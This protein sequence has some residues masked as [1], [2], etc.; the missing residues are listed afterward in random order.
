M[1]NDLG[2]FSSAYRAEVLKV[3]TPDR[4][5]QNPA[6]YIGST[7]GAGLD[8][9]V[10][11]LV[12]NSLA[13]AEQGH[14]CTVGVR[15]HVDGSIEVIDEGR[16]PALIPDSPTLEEVLTS[17]QGVPSFA[18]ESQKREWFYYSVAAALS[19]RVCVE[20]SQYGSMFQQVFERSRRLATPKRLSASSRQSFSFRFKPDPAIFGEARITAFDIRDKLLEVAYLHSAANGR[21][22]M[23]KACLGLNKVSLPRHTLP[24]R[25]MP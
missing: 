21:N 25:G 11:R 6:M 15:F 17:I 2:G 9:L 20:F 7:R 16:P 4:V 10:T 18:D 5:R 14:A 23:K 13:E 19:E 12:F 24:N 8:E 3:V 22:Q 1:S